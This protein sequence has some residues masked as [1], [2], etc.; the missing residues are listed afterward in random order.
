MSHI[1]DIN[2]WLMT[3]SRIPSTCSQWSPPKIT[4]VGNKVTEIIFT[5]SREFITL[6]DSWEI[7]SQSLE[8]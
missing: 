7:L 3:Y 5:G 2:R 1:V 6:A 4:V 8:P